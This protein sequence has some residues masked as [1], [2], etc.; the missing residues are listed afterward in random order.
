MLEILRHK[1][2]YTLFFL[3]ELILC[4]SGLQF[5]I[6]DFVH[7]LERIRNHL[8]GNKKESSLEAFSANQFK[9]NCESFSVAAQRG[10]LTWKFVK[11]ELS[12]FFP[13]NF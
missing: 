11:A 6:N 1:A 10:T 12:L 4:F 3:T 2:L 9:M 8:Q 13:E 5:H 7:F